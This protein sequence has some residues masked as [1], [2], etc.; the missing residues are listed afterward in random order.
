MPDWRRVVRRR[1]RSLAVPPRRREQI[2][3]EMAGFLEDLYEERLELGE[4][5]RAASR[6]AIARAGRWSEV[7]RELERVEG[8][9]ARRLRTLWLPGLAVAI[10]TQ[11]LLL[12]L[13]ELGAAQV[14]WHPPQPP[15]FL[16]W[17]WLAALPLMGAA[18]ATWSR[19]QGG[20]RLECALVAVFPVLAPWALLF[21]VGAARV[22]SL[23]VPT[24]EKLLVLLV[25]GLLNWVVLPALALFLGALP[26][27]RRPDGAAQTA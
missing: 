16:C 7:A 15:V 20:S 18:G 8:H 19:R 23:D 27:L 21:P 6:T 4:S 17:P 2:V 25:S 9:V 10:A 3:R 14:V 26:V 22:L 5:P 11:G 13:G 12:V 24:S 1:L